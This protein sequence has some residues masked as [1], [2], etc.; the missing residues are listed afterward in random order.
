MVGSQS[1][2]WVGWLARCRPSVRSRKILDTCAC[3]S[4]RC[5]GSRQL[6]ISR[7]NRMPMYGD[8]DDG[9]D[10]GDRRRRLPV[11]GDVDGRGDG[12]RRV[13]HDDGQRDPVSGVHGV[14]SPGRSRRRPRRILSGV[15][16]P[17]VARIR[18]PDRRTAASRAAA[19]SRVGRTSA[20]C[21]AARPGTGSSAGR[22]PPGDPAACRTAQTASTA[23]PASVP[24]A[25]GHVPARRCGTTRRR[26]G[27]DQLPDRSGLGVADHQG[28]AVDLVDPV[29]GGHQGIDGVVH[30]RG[31][32]QC[33]ARSRAPAACRVGPGRRC[34]RPA[35][36]RPVPRP[37]AVGSPAPAAPDRRRP[38]RSARPS[39][40]CARSARVRAPGRPA[41]RPTPTN[42]EPA[43]ATEGDDTCTRRDTPRS[44]QACD[45]GAGAGDVGR[46][47]VRP[48]SRRSPPWRR[49]GPRRRS[50]RRRA[51]PP[52]G[53]RR[54]RGS[55]AVRDR[56]AGAAGR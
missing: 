28:P 39:P 49:G 17:P 23:A 52:P 24:T 42:E 19:G 55:P 51:G 11:P 36:C 43:W 5:W 34:V 1:G 54:R 32:D 37:G 47:E 12:D 16:T 40:C 27:G 2:H 25:T 29:D 53:R 48:P 4:R 7:K 22:S 18:W 10:P 35:G 6:P 46:Q 20:R 3:L 14:P 45:D 41:R 44:R 9:H 50:P 13:Q 38:A 26:D 31:V 30:V 21:S 8:E 15:A 56:R 33:R